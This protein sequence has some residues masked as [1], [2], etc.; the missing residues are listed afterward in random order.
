MLLEGRFRFWFGRSP[1]RISREGRE[2]CRSHK[3]WQLVRISLHP[4][5]QISIIV[6]L[7]FLPKM[8]IIE[9]VQLEKS[10]TIE[11]IR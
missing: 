9:G 1:S 11:L 6:A 2:L 8:M 3:R 5:V 10:Q 4:G 7:P